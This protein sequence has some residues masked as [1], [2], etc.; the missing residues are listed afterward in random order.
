M[1][2][3]FLGMK[4]T[5]FAL[6][7]LGIVFQGC[8]KKDCTI[9]DP[10]TSNEIANYKC[11]SNCK[12]E[13]EILSSVQCLQCITAFHD[14][15]LTCDKALGDSLIAAYTLNTTAG[16]CDKIDAKLDCGN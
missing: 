4:K 9:R 16:H 12:T 11:K 3:V 2:F 7:A 1:A 5:I 6:F 15:I 14:T 13:A 10:F 8:M